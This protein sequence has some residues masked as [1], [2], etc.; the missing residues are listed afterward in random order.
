MARPSKSVAVL[1]KE[2]KSHRTKAELAAREAAE[3]ECLTGRKL[4]FEKENCMTIK[5]AAHIIPK[6]PE[7]KKNPLLEALSGDG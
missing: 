5:S 7:N 6:K 2:G 4:H 1:K 3:Q